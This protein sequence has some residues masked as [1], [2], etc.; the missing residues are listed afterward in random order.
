[1]FII[2]RS[3]FKFKSFVLAMNELFVL[4]LGVLML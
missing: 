2:M 3:R 1:L 4:Q